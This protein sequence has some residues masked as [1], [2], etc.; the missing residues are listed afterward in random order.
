MTIAEVVDKFRNSHGDQL[1]S[2]FSRAIMKRWASVTAFIFFILLLAGAFF[3]RVDVSVI[4]ENF[5]STDGS[6]T[7]N[8]YTNESSAHNASPVKC[9][10]QSTCKVNDTVR[11]FDGPEYQLSDAAC[12]DYFRWIHEDLRPWASTGIS[13]DTVESA[14]RFATFRLVIVDGKAYVE[15][16]YHSFQ[17]RDLFTIW[18]IV[19]LLRLYPGRVPDV[20]LMFQCGDLPEIQKGDYQGPGATLPPPALFQYSGNETAFAVTF[21]D[22]SFWGWVE[23]DIKPWKSMLEGITKGSQ[24][25]NWTDRVPYAYWRGNS[26][27]S[28]DRKDLLK[29]KSSIFSHDWNARLYSQ[30]WGKETHNGFKHSHL[31][32]QCT[33]RYKIYIEGRAWSVSDKYILACDSMTLLIKPDYYDFFMRS[34][35]PMQHYWPIRKTNKCRDIKF[36]VDWGNNHADKAETIGK[37]GS[38]FIHDNLKMEYVYGYM[39]HLFREYAKLMKFKPEIPQ[40]G[41][42]V[43]AESMACSEGGLI[44]EFMESSMEISPSSTLPCAMP[45]YDPAFLQDFSERKENIT[46]QVVMWENEYWENKKKKTKTF[47]LKRSGAYKLATTVFFHTFVISL[48]FF[49]ILN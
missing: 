1:R 34:M 3:F 39:L 6:T 48:T 23:V 24:R 16:Y 21:P 20:E 31:E 33:H 43:C 17:T 27:V 15:R 19:Q 44:R 38:A 40:G 5:L 42:E 13:R 25:K 22:W 36:A 7:Q 9:A 4:G 32:D 35:I 46:R 18:G 47:F 29:C 41:V 26:H 8:I 14:K 30:D 12:P 10:D 28:R 49:K 11:A 45:P 37:G 2:H